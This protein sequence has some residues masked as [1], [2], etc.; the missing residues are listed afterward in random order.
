MEI[1]GRLV[2]KAG[3]SAYDAGS[4]ITFIY[5][6]IVHLFDNVKLT[7]GGRNRKCQSC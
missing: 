2:K 7:V 5:N 1:H 3:E 6:G 4:L